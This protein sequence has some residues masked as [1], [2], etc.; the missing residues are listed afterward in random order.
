MSIAK[1]YVLV[2][3]VLSLLGACS[4]TPVGA[5]SSVVPV[6]TSARSAPSANTTQG[7]A[8]GSMAA[9]TTR[10]APAGSVSGTSLPPYLDPTSDLLTARSVYFDFDEAL[11]KTEFSGLVQRHGTYL[12]SNPGLVVRIEGNTDERGSAEYNLALGQ[13]RAEAVK[14]ALKLAGVR[15]TQMEAISWGKER[16]RA[17]GHSEQDWGQNRRADIQYPAR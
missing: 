13:K 12:S 14:Q 15:E 11:L 7:S 4:S 2:A 1:S 8:P 17:V 6:N 3:V 5:P 16:P 9:A 10:Q